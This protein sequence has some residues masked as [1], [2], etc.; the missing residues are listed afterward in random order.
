[1]MSRKL[2]TPSRLRENLYRILDRI[3][4]TGEPVGISRRG[5]RLKIVAD[6]P[7]RLDALRPRPDFIVGDPEDLVEID[8]SAEWRP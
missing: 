7:R 2:F 4:E 1:M 6:S 3:L 8:W 5:R